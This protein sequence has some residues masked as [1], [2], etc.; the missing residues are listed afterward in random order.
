VNYRFD[1][2]LETVIEV[3]VNLLRELLVIEGVQA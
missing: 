2:F 1:L 3:I